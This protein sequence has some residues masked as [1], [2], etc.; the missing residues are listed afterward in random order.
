MPIIPSATFLTAQFDSLPLYGTSLESNGRN[1][2]AG[3]KVN[4]NDP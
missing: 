3:W 1:G 2:S 4:L